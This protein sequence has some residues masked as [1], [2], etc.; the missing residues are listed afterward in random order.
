VAFVDNIDDD[1]SCGFDPNDGNLVADPL[2]TDLIEY[3]NPNPDVPLLL[4]GFE[5]T[6]DSPAID[7]E[8]N[9][10][11]WIPP[12]MDLEEDQNGQSRDVD[13]NDDGIATCDLGALEAPENNDAIFADRFDG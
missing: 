11:C 6:L 2:L 1:G 3:D 13:G 10:M 4:P 9:S 7:Y 12:G 8:D 5:L